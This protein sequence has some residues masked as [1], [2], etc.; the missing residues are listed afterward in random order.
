MSET[1]LSTES[2]TCMHLKK[3]RNCSSRRRP[4][5]HFRHAQGNQRACV[6]TNSI[7]IF[8]STVITVYEVVHQKAVNTKL[9]KQTIWRSELIKEFQHYFQQKT[10][11]NTQED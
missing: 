10:G 4:E 6:L 5:P 2:K 9:G 11:W 3:L 7:N 1:Y 8:Q